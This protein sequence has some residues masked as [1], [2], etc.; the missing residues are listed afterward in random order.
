MKNNKLEYDLTYFKIARDAYTE[1][2][3]NHYLV[4]KCIKNGA[5]IYGLVEASLIRQIEVI[6]KDLVHIVELETLERIHNKEF[7][8]ASRLPYFGAILKGKGKRVLKEYIKQGGFEPDEK[9]EEG[10]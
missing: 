2:N 8:G 9:T 1:L 7:D 4:M 5:D 3:H 10:I 6:D